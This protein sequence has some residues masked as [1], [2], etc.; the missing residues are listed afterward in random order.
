MN[1]ALSILIQL[2]MS[3][4]LIKV[5]EKI[6]SELGIKLKT[7][8]IVIITLVIITDSILY[9]ITYNTL[10]IAHVSLITGYLIFMS[11]TDMKTKLLYSTVS[12]VMIAIETVLVLLSIASI[13]KYSFI[14]LVVPFGLFILSLFKMLGLGDVYI[15]LVISLYYLQS[16]PLAFE[17]ILIN[18]ILADVLFVISALIYKIATK[19]K[20]K[21]LPFTIYI[22]IATT[23]CN[24]LLI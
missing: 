20:E 4:S 19:E 13:Y 9:S 2:I 8:D 14:V 6:D 5:F 23:V 18:V 12:F 3:L 16:R 15:Y 1:L 11:Y 21:H 17:S 22:G 24:I 10:N 7:K